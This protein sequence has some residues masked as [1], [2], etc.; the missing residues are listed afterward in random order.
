VRNS[1]CK[2]EGHSGG[3]ENNNNDLLVFGRLLCSRDEW[4]NVWLENLVV[5]LGCSLGSIV[6]KE[7]KCAQLD[8]VVVWD[9]CHKEGHAALNNAK[10]AVDDLCFF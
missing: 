9:H 1:T 3:D 8:E 4:N 5:Y 7:D 2:K 6:V 10:C